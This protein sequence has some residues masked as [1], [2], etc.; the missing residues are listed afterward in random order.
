MD[1]SFRKP[2]FSKK[3]LEVRFE[4]NVVCI[5][6]TGEGLRKLAELCNGLVDDPNEGHI[7][8]E[9][10]NLLTGNSDKCAIAIFEKD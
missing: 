7:H 8:L 9:N 2:D 3:G 6:G 5:Y 4:D 1:E 10:L